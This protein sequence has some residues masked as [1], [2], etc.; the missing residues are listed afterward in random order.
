MKE[1]WLRI[2]IANDEEKDKPGSYCED[3]GEDFKGSI[4]KCQC[5]YCQNCCI[6]LDRH[7]RE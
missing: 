3:C 2:D 4:V 6:C 5:G 1:G 7:E